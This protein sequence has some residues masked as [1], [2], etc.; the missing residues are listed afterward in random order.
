MPGLW[1]SSDACHLE[2]PS[3]LEAALASGVEC[4][5]SIINKT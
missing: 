3:T 1:L 4:A 2:Y 5:R